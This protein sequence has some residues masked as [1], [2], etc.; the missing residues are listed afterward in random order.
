MKTEIKTKV[1]IMFMLT[2]NSHKS[3]IS[4]Y[5]AFEHLRQSLFAKK[6]DLFVMI[7]GY[8]DD[9]GTSANERA[10]VVA[11]YLG[12][13]SQW[14]NFCREWSQF[15]ADYGITEMHRADLETFHGEFLEEYGWNPER[16]TKCVRDAHRII[17]KNT[18]TALSAAVIKADF[19]EIIPDDIKKLFGGAYGWAALMCIWQSYGWFYKQKK[20]SDINWVFEAGTKGRNEFDKIMANIYRRHDLRQQFKI[21]GWSFNS[22]KVLPLQAADVIAYESFKQIDGQIIDKGKRPVRRSAQDLFRPSEVQHLRYQDREGLKWILSLPVAQRF[23][24]FAK[25][26]IE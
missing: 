26:E 7:S 16:R 8:F 21:W 5:N 11:G 20:P 12:S 15:L 2:P 13:V 6:G 10:A 24:S 23:F 18:Y 9:S 1:A 3:Y 14:D 19:D 17:K 25:G 4:R 22:K